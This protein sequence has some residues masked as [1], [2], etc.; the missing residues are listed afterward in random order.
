L[1]KKMTQEGID[2]QEFQ[3]RL[4]REYL[5]DKVLRK[6]VYCRLRSLSPKKRLHAISSPTNRTEKGGWQN[7]HLGDAKSEVRDRIFKAKADRAIEEY[8]GKLRRRA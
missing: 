8:F 3:Y 6:E 1:A 7:T 5:R 4:K 2:L